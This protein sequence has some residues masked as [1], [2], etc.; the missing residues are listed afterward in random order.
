LEGGWGVA[1]ETELGGFA[2]A[3]VFCRHF[4]RRPHGRRTEERGESWWCW[5]GGQVEAVAALACELQH[6]VQKW[7]VRVTVSMAIYCTL[8]V[9]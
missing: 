9:D 3:F 1:P 4:E 7:A 5:G 2:V 6:P 8:V